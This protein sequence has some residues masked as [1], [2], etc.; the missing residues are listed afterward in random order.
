MKGSGKIILMI[1]AVTSLF[2]FYVHGQ[3]T[4]FRVSYEIEGQNEA[5]NHLTDTY[6]QLKFDVE[7]LKAPRRLEAKLTDHSM[8]LTVPQQI[9]VMRVPPPPSLSM[10]QLNDVTSTSMSNR[11][12]DFFGRWIGVAQAKTEN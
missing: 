10:Q 6:R 7:R 9:H 11:V 5:I 3:V 2:V 12:L 8:D 4:L 1:A